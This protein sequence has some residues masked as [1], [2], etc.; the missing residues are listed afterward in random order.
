PG[1]AL[2]AYVVAKALRHDLVELSGEQLQSYYECAEFSTSR[3][4]LNKISDHLVHELTEAVK[5]L[6]EAPAAVRAEL[7]LETFNLYELGRLIKLSSDALFSTQL[8][9]AKPLD[10]NTLP[11]LNFKAA[12]YEA[13]DKLKELEVKL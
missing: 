8:D 10:L 9:E 11:G 4:V 1:V 12:L 13:Q 3:A 6:N 7:S 2:R 5:S